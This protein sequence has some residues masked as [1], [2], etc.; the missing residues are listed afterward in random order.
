M[1]QEFISGKWTIII[2]V[3]FFSMVIVHHI[4]R[5]ERTVDRIEQKIDKIE[6][7]K[8]GENGK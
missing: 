3:F 2:F 8:F 4:K 6:Q 7:K 5:T 1:K